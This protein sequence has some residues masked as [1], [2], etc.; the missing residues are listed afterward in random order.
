MP[1]KKSTQNA[2]QTAANEARKAEREAKALAKAAAVNAGPQEDAAAEVKPAKAP[3]TPKAAAAPK[4]EKPA[5]AVK[6]EKAAAVLEHETAHDTP[7]HI[8]GLRYAED[9]SM[10][11]DAPSQ[12]AVVGELHRTKSRTTETVIIV[13]RTT[14]EPRW[15]DET[16]GKYAAICADHGYVKYYPSRAAAFEDWTRPMATGCPFCA[17]YVGHNER[18][19]DDSLRVVA[20]PEPAGEGDS[21]VLVPPS[22][23]DKGDNEAPEA[24]AED[25]VDQELLPV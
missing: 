25:A 13:V 23:T 15:L 10:V 3:K 24:G 19:E 8:T 21:E 7:D 9:G 2:A 1:S 20:E 6:A 17:Y 14:N 12:R 16:R 4:A 5:K 22:P 11:P 18:R